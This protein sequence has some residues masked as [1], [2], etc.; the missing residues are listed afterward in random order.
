MC[1]DER[2][3]RIVLFDALGREMVVMDFA[4]MYRDTSRSSLNN[5]NLFTK[6]TYSKHINRYREFW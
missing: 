6:H 3:G 1:V 5:S 2:S 4:L